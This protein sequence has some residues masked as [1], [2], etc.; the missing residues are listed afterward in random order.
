[1][2]FYLIRVTPDTDSETLRASCKRFIGPWQ[3]L[4]RSIELSPMSPQGRSGMHLN[5]HADRA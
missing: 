3:A 5:V 4:K 2:E 1:M